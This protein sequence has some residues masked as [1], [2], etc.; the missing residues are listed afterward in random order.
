MAELADPAVPGVT[1]AIGMEACSAA[2]PS[3]GS[4]SGEGT[5]GSATDGDAAEGCRNSGKGFPRA[6]P[7]DESAA[8]AATPPAQKTFS[9]MVS[10]V[11]SSLTCSEQSALSAENAIM[12]PKHFCQIHEFRLALQCPA[13]IL[14]SSKDMIMLL[15]RYRLIFC[16]RQSAYRQHRGVVLSH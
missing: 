7:T 15:E 3:E 10:A 6:V 4:G 8:A 11:L 2:D 13:V 16:F 1:V 5:S 9:R 12:P 14:H